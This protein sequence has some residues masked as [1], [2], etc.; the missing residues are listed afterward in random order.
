LHVRGYPDTLKIQITVRSMTS[1]KSAGSQEKKAQSYS[2]YNEINN[3]VKAFLALARKHKRRGAVLDIGEGEGKYAI[4]FARHGFEGHGIHNSAEA[5]KR[6][7]AFA[8]KTGV[9]ESTH[10]RVGDAFELP[11]PGRFFDIVIDYGYL[12]HIRKGEWDTYLESILRVMKEDAFYMLTVYNLRDRH[13]SGRKR[14][15]VIHQG[16]YDYFFGK[17]EL[18]ELLMPFFEILKISEENLVTSE[19][20][21]HSYYHVQARRLL[22]EKE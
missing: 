18:R 5:I 14:H 6:A 22:P 3:E 15:Y 11:Y 17:K 1:S 8:S 2:W 19:G 13:V 7:R 9:N 10:F 16:H 20:T 21:S 4:F 12:H